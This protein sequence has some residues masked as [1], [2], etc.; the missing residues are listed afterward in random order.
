MS[1]A[2][3]SGDI[4]G[5]LMLTGKSYSK[6]YGKSYSKRLECVCVCGKV[7]FTDFAQLRSERTK[8]CGCRR[9]E[10]I[11]KS[12][13]KHGMSSEKGGRNVLY[14]TW[15]AIKNR[16]KSSRKREQMCYSDK[17]IKVSKEWIDSFESFYNWSIQNGWQKGL[18]LDR[19]NNDGNYSSENCRWVTMAE[20]MRNTR[21]TVF[22]TAFGDKKCIADWL[23]DGRCSAKRTTLTNRIRDGWDIEKA[24]TTK[25]N[26]KRWQA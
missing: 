23:I 13:F 25:P 6:V 20:Q 17:G 7:F 14:R 4:Y 21:M 16:C 5:Y 8:S 10:F 9:V 18:T 2:H 3:K 11:L 1:Y 15:I 24:I 22:L 19:R 12:T 26:G